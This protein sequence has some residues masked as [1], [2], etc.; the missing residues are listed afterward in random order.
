MRPF[1]LSRGTFSGS[2]KYTA[3]WLGDNISKWPDMYYSIP[4]TLNFNLFG[5]PFV[6]VSVFI[7]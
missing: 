4:G 5:I 7:I 1:I 3:H 6:S 2:G